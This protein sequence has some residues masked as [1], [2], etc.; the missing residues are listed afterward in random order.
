MD[1][2]IIRVRA[3]HGE[4]AL[5]GKFHTRSNIKYDRL[6]ARELNT[7]EPFENTNVQDVIDAF[8]F[9]F[10]CKIFFAVD[11][12]D[13][14]PVYDFDIFEPSFNSL[15]DAVKVADELARRLIE[16]VDKR[17]PIRGVPIINVC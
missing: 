16:C 1:G 2:F 10:R 14:L 3:Y 17:K 8:E 13:G 9:Q 6:I 5:I 15:G 12:D 11:E 4:A 7:F